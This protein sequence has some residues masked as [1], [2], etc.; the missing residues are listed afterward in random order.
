MIPQDKAMR[1]EPD[2]EPWIALQQMDCDGANQLP[3]VT[4]NRVVG[5]LGHEDFITC[6]RTVQARA[7]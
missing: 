6:L 7:S 4:D 5:L 2:K 1:I 3:V